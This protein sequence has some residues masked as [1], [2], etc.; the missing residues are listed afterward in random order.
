M[1]KYSN[2]HLL[3]LD[4]LGAEKPTE[5]VITTLYLIINRRY[6]N[7][8]TTVITSNYDYNDLADIIDER[9]IDRIDRSYLIFEK[10]AK[11]KTK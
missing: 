1:D 2:A 8:L 7:M 3:V 5:F 6:E 11:W 10:T 4:D 9:I